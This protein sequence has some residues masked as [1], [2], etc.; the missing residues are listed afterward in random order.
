MR[1]PGVHANQRIA[2]LAEAVAHAIHTAPSP[3][4]AMRQFTTLLRGE[5][6][7]LAPPGPPAGPARHCPPDA[8]LRSSCPLSR[9]SK[10]FSQIESRGGIKKFSTSPRDG[11]APHVRQGR[12]T[13]Q[14]P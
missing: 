8:L 1:R 5:L 10:I 12:K 4:A 7:V 2:S 13:I 14:T 3:G 9:I 11:T 6:H